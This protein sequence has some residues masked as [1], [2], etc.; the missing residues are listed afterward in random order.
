MQ[1]IL[2]DRVSQVE[3][4]NSPESSNVEPLN[5][6]ED[7]PPRPIEDKSYVEEFDNVRETLYSCLVEVSKNL[8]K[9]TTR[10]SE[11]VTESYADVVNPT[12]EE[13]LFLK[14]ILHYF[15]ETIEE[16]RNILKED[17][18]SMSENFQAT[19][20][21]SS[22]NLLNNAQRLFT[23]IQSSLIDQ[24]IVMEQTE[25]LDKLKHSTTALLFSIKELVAEL[26]NL[27]VGI[28]A[29]QVSHTNKNK[30]TQLHK[31]YDSTQYDLS[32]I[33][34]DKIKLLQ[35]TIRTWTLGRKFRAIVLHYK[36]SQEDDVVRH[37]GKALI[38][39]R[40]TEKSYVESL[41][42]C[43]KNFYLP[44]KKTSENS[45]WLTLSDVEALFNNYSM[46]IEFSKKLLF[47][48]EER[49]KRWPI[50]QLFGDILID[51]SKDMIVYA[52]YVNGF[53]CALQV[54]NRLKLIPDFQALERKCIESCK[55][56]MDL[57]SY[58]IMPVQR[59]PRYQ[60]LIKELLK[61]TS[62]DH[63]DYN[64]LNEALDTIT[65]LNVE[66]NR[67][68]REYDNK[69]K[70]MQLSSSITSDKPIELL[71]E[72]RNFISEALPTVTTQTSKYQ[73]RV[74]LFNDI[75]L[76]LRQEKKPQMTF[77]YEG[78]IQLDELGMVEIKKNKKSC[79]IWDKSGK[80]SF[81]CTLSFSNEKELLKWQKEITSAVETFSL[82]AMLDSNM[83]ETPT[84]RHLVILSAMY[85]DLSKP[86]NSIDVTQALQSIVNSSGNLKLPETSKSNLP[87]F[88][89]PAKGKKKSL[90]VVYQYNGI[91]KTKTVVDEAGLSLP[92]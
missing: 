39:I 17:V 25:L 13:H 55:R 72:G 51:H 53:D 73:G 58:L 61:L 90:M 3:S 70:I 62:K 78:T 79:T 76:I 92:E 46:I 34:E 69:I 6:V 21:S 47:D 71:K 57:Q 67:R 54:Y 31:Q 24:T 50:N 44:L 42:E 60:L 64:N 4:T 45:S 16:M 20:S 11:L 10:I 30:D 28:E 9:N 56:R 63:I 40:D 36:T 77:F 49:V 32:S 14:D 87:G 22:Q 29:H 27:K 88:T 82:R 18:A 7:V 52:D 75:L 43:S 15:Q 38:E 85:G 74:C 5:V 91:V 19:I 59:V 23:F 26:D 35:S 84:N 68:K 65:K 89:D 66:I 2:N 12:S 48:F 1:Q 86:K 80:K 33:P 8:T 41:E 81:E 37:R 83:K